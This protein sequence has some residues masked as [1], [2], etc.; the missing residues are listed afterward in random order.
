M[1]YTW[2]PVLMIIG[3]ASEVLG[4]LLVAS[5]FAKRCWDALAG[6]ISSKIKEFPGYINETLDWIRRHLP[7]SERWG[8]TYTDTAHIGTLSM[9]GTLRPRLQYGWNTDQP[10]SEQLEEI[11]KNIDR[12]HR[13]M[14]DIPESMHDQWLADIQQES[15]AL[16]DRRLRPFKE[17]LNDVVLYPRLRGAGVVLL[18]LGI[19]LA[20]FGNL[21]AMGW[22]FPQ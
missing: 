10:V 18:L 1:D 12:L 2:G 8:R 14:Q 3:G 9:H 22:D 17:E 11:R 15:S 19:L 6:W 16:I 20:V 5:P 7:P 13:E 4:V 21:I